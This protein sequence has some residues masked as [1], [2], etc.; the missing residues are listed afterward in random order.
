[1]LKAL[2]QLVVS[3]AKGEFSF[4][5]LTGELD[6]GYPIVTAARKRFLLE[7]IAA[8]HGIPLSE[9]MCVGDGAN[10][11][12]MLRA[13]GEAGGIGVA[14]KAKEKVQKVAPNRLNGSS[15]LDLL[16]LT[17]RTE[18]EVNELVKY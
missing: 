15:L 6:P 17:G 7:K 8:E 9:T 18:A 13:V 16:Y 5:H 1:M 11:L 4:P 12:E 14:F 10:D 3:S 2:S